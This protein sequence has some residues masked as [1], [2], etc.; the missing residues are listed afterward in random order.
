MNNRIIL[1]GT[2]LAVIG[3]STPFVISE[4]SVGPEQPNC[5]LPYNATDNQIESLIKMGCSI[6]IS[7]SISDVP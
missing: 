7:G 1:I 6:D 2:I 4:I 5:E 3:L